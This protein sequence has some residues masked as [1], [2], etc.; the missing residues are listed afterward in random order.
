MWIKISIAMLAFA[1]NSLLCRLALAEQQIDPMSFSLLRVGSGVVCLGLFYAVLQVQ[2]PIQF[3][4]KSALSLAV[5]LLGFSLAYL[6]I[7][8]GI[9]AL[10]LFGAVQITMI[11]YAILH[12][13]R[14]TLPRWVG[15]GCAILG[16]GLLLLP[17]ASTPTFKYALMM[18][19]AGIAWGF[20]SIAAKT[21]QHALTNTLSNF[22]LAT[23]LVA[24]FFLWHLPESFITW[25]GVVL[26]VLSGALASAGAYVL[27]YSIVKKIDH[28]TASTVQLS[29]PCLAILG[30]VIFL[31]EQLTLLMVI[32]TLIVL[33]GILMVILTKPRV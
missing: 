31:G 30:G 32:A 22:I 21:M 33:C 8:A 11:S 15:L 29:V 17:E 3:Q 24:V 2:Q 12:G 4:W 20:Y 26:A 10:I 23:P 25:Q 16:M 6:H 13:E 19:L 27:W 5:Y 14:M 28:I 7:D 18:L 9:G 1:A